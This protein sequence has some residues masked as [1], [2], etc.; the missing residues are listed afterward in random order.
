VKST[1]YFKTNL[2]TKEQAAGSLD[3]GSSGKI[4]QYSDAMKPSLS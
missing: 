3:E 2:L 1:G 4:T